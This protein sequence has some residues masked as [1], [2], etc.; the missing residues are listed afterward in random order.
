MQFNNTPL[1]LE[2]FNYAAKYVNPYV[3]YDLDD[4]PKFHLEILN[5][6]IASLMRLL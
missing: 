4:L 6:K 2:Q 5:A 3:V 1:V